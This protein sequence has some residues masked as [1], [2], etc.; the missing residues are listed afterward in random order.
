MLF[1]TYYDFIKIIL[2]VNIPYILYKIIKHRRFIRIRAQAE[3]Y[4][5]CKIVPPNGWNP[6][7]EKDIMCNS[8][9]FP[10]KKQPI[11][12]L[13]EGQGFDDGNQYDMASY[14]QMADAFYK[15]WI[16]QYNNGKVMSVDKVCKEYWDLV[17]TNKRPATVEYGN[18]L[19]TTAYTS[20]FP[21]NSPATCE[22][23]TELSSPA[24]VE[25]FSPEYYAKSSWNLNNLPSAEGSILKYLKAKINGVNVPWLYVGMLF[26]SFCWHNEDNY[27]Y[28]INYSH[29]GAI[30]QWYGVS[31]ANATKFEAVM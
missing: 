27:F 29:F 17:E 28:S 21:V 5:I 26:S 1:F 22:D 13:Q 24:E 12:Q 30:K 31:G 9:K 2:Y 16:D 18:D 4:G 7:S 8:K 15:N 19:D 11:N 3:P 23:A 10:T 6:D 20:G 25:M 14:K